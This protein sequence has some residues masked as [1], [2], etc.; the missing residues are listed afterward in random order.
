M[1]NSTLGN[2]VANT[3]GSVSFLC[4]KCESTTITRT[5]NE[6]EIAAKYTC[7]DCGFTGPN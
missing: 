5:R 1:A 7:T 4:P 3:A 6:R 2:N